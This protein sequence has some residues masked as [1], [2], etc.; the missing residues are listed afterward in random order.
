MTMMVFC[1]KVTNHFYIWKF[2]CHSN[3]SPRLKYQKLLILLHNYDI[4]QKNF[5]FYTHVPCTIYF[6]NISVN[7]VGAFPAKNVLVT[8]ATVTYRSISLF[9][10]WMSNIMY[11]QNTIWAQLCNTVP[12]SQWI[13]FLLRNVSGKYQDVT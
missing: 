9:G 11:L 1:C 2:G 4:T 6:I 7:C 3:S 5:Q 12:F 13:A 8:M 10:P